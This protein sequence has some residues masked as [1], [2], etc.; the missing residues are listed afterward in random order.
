MPSIPVL[1]LTTAV[2]SDHRSVRRDSYE[3]TNN[4]ESNH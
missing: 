4:H 2:T 3:V 1:P